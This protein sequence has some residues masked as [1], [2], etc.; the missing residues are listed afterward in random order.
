ML[1]E[2]RTSI[3]NYLYNVFHG[4][5]TDNVYIVDKPQELTQSDVKDGFLVI[6]LGDMMDGSEFRGEA[7]ARVRCYI[8][9]YIPPATRG[10]LNT[11]KFT[12]FENAINSTIDDVIANNANA[13]YGVE[14]GSFLS[15]DDFDVS[16][17][18]NPFHTFT[19]S[20]VITI[21]NAE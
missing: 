7:Y 20:F 18:N 14:E 19:R 13:Q 3:Y 9:A 8:T 11:K 15:L 2:S 17:A 1:N 10:R 21:E 16:N 4:V 6:M 5:V 12:M